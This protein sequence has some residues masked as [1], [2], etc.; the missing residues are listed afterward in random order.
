[1]GLAVVSLLVLLVIALVAI[2]VL[3]R[4]FREAANRNPNTPR[5]RE[6]ENRR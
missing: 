1:M 3:T 6:D 4:V 5:D 2:P